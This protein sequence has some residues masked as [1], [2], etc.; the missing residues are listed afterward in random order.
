MRLVL[1]LILLA[2]SAVQAT[3]Q[4]GRCYMNVWG[5]WVCSGRAPEDPFEPNSS[6]RRRYREPYAP[7]RCERD[8][9]SCRSPR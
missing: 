8:P 9:Y 2:V 6:Y 4:Q 7:T 1:V 5:H 3:A